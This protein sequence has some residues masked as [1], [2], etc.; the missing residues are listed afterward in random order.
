[1]SDGEPERRDRG[2]ADQVSD[3][4]LLRRV[5]QGETDAATQ[6]YLRY[7][8]RLLALARSKTS[9]ALSRRVDSD[10]I[11]QSVFGSFF[12]G[13]QQGYYDVPVGEELWKLF[14]VIALNKI[15]AKGAFHLAAKRDVRKTTDGDAIDKLADAAPTDD[16]TAL[17]VLKLTLTEALDQLPVGHREMI[18]L[19]IEGHEIDEIAR[20]TGRSKRTVERM[21]QEARKRLAELLEFE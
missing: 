18:E 8:Q 13:A 11:V 19:R 9:S 4:S 10:E 2:T 12:R 16:E 6:L 20:R 7:A 15:R 1:M 14:L 3:H 21:L 5:K 17:Q